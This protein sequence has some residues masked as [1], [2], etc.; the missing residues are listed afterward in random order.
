[1]ASPLNAYKMTCSELCCR[2][3]LDSRATMSPTSYFRALSSLTR[4][5]ALLKKTSEVP[6]RQVVKTAE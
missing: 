1:M 2:C 5:L 3:S 6:K 4:L